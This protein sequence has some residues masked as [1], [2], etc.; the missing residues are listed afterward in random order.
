M[1]GYSREH[2]HSA[3]ETTSQ[4]KTLPE[5]KQTHLLPPSSRLALSPAHVMQL[6]KTIGN[7]AVL[8]LLRKNVVQSKKNE[9]GM[10]DTLKSGLERLSGIDLSNVKV[11]YQSD[12]PKQLGALAYAQGTNIHLGPGQERHLPHEGWHVVQQMQGRVK[13]TLQM[14]DVGVAV[15]DEVGLE[16]EANQ[17]GMK[18]LQ[19]DDHLTDYDGSQK[20]EAISPPAS[21]PIQGVWESATVQDTGEE[22]EVRPFDD[23]LYH[24][25]SNV[26]YEVVS[27]TDDELVLRRYVPTTMATSSTTTTTT[28]T[29]ASPMTTTP[30]TPTTTPSTISPSST[31]FHPYSKGFSKDQKKNVPIETPGGP[32]AARHHRGAPYITSKAA[33][34]N[35]AKLGSKYT[36]FF[37]GMRGGESS[38]DKDHEIAEALLNENASYFKTDTQKRGYAMFDG[39]INIAEENRRRG[40]GKIS[41]S[42]LRMIAKKY[43]KYTFKDYLKKFK[44]VKSAKLGRKQTGDIKDYF[45]TYTELDESDR[46][47]ADHMS[48]KQADDFSED[49]VEEDTE[50]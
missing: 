20:L 47:I 34:Y 38:T 32:I 13:P 31:R 2:T 18:A 23:I 9:T 25:I 30:S 50:E 45:A 39:V 1:K 26:L 17:M 15:N 7:Q 6:Q 19:Q 5:Q 46:E 10:P 40:A 16:D 3:H 21:K 36:D 37:W 33:D 12:K 27:H 22:I 29:I 14:Q 35:G 44:F 24:D 42:I 48:P 43:K 4:Q 49:E 41:R 8:Q 28:T 11:H